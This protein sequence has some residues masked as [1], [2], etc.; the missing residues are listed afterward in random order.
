M[1][2]CEFGL[3]FEL[4]NQAT[5]LLSSPAFGRAVLVEVKPSFLLVVDHSS[6]ALHELLQL[7]LAGGDGKAA[8]VHSINGEGGISVNPFD[9]ADFL[10]SELSH[11]IA[12]EQ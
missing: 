11:R 6:I 10:G 8:V 5:N 12:P 1:F 4:G 7:F 3:A 9:L 2:S